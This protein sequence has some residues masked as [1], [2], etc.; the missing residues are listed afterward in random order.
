LS[1]DFPK[2]S[3]QNEGVHPQGMIEDFEIF[4]YYREK[5]MGIGYGLL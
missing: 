5:Q 2:E 1:T 3:R 4:G